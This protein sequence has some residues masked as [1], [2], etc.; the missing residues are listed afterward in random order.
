[1]PI[2]WER[3]AMVTVKTTTGKGRKPLEPYL[4][5]QYAVTFLTNR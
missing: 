4:I 3:I 1:M 2:A 5:R